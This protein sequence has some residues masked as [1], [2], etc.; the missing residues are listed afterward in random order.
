MGWGPWPTGDESSP[1]LPALSTVLALA[2]GPEL[3]KLTFLGLIGIIDPPRAGVKEAVQ[4]LSESGLSVKMITG[5]A[6][7]TALAIGTREGRGARATTSVYSSRDLVSRAHT[8]L[9]RARERFLRFKDPYPTARVG[10]CLSNIGRSSQR[11][12]G[13]V[14]T[15]K[16]LRAR[17]VRP[18]MIT[19]HLHRPSLSCATS[20]VPLANQ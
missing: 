9:P 6:L 12:K 20:H 3:G 19:P 2:S 8:C 1:N 17:A 11:G 7:E 15:E 13:L 16:R 5:D 4:V 18:P 14:H 10:V